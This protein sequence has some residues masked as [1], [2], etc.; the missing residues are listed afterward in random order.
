MTEH[1]VVV[2]GSGINA[3]VAAA[4]LA[5]AGRDVGVYERAPRLGGAIRTE[6]DTPAPGYTTDLL[7]C[8]HPLFVGGPA[9]PAL[10]D[11]LDRRGVVYRN[12]DLPSA[13][14]L[15]DGS[16]AVL[17]TDADVTAA[18]FE[19]LAPGDGEAWQS[20]LTEFGSRAGLAFGALG[21]EL[22]SLDGL[23]LALTALW[24]LGPRGLLQFGAEGLE[25]ARSWLSGRFTSPT[26]HGLLSPWVGHEGLGPDDAFSGFINKVIALA[27]A[28]G[29]CP[30][31]VGG[32]VR[33]VEALAGIVTDAG[34]TART[35]ADVVRIE[36]AGGR[37]TG[38][39]LADGERI[40][41]REAVLASVTPQALYLRLLPGSAVPADVRDAARGYRYGR[42]DMQVHLALSE[43]PRWADDQ[44]RLSR[45]AIVHVSGGMDDV[46]RAVNEAQRHLLPAHPT[47]VAGQPAALDPTR[48]PAG[49]GAL[50]LQLQ[51]TPGR[52]VGDAAGEI[53]VGD[54][55]WTEDLR[56]RYADRVVDRLGR[57][58]TNLDSALVGR[59]VLSP[60]DLEAWNS[61]LVGGDPYSGAC[62]L[63][64]FLVWRPTART[65]GH[66]TPVRGLW[67][68]GASTHP[69]PGLGG[70][71]GLLAVQQVLAR[72][73]RPALLR[74]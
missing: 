72:G 57:H 74:R 64:Q 13:A 47:I 50:W 68:I 14:V 56:E 10:Q 20:F 33:L 42:G 15:T 67:H 52:P 73:R 48:V 9:Y 11:E 23:R 21:T 39:A 60:G 19:R 16:T 28:Q 17:S 44:D 46:S 70:A 65:R 22:V 24:Q 43:P 32:G 35:D 54:G 59:R 3:L 40:G 36:T 61:N 5:R 30:V 45:A 49:A 8:W 26:V 18:D 38:V 12:T 7:S 27:L 6:T 4:T 58:V 25:S 29:G 62:T 53:D 55:T 37:A 69:G 63:D 34:G 1:D 2:V 31:P 41:A 51:E 66:R 71:S